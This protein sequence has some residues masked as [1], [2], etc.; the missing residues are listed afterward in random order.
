FYDSLE[1]LSVSE[2]TLSA[3][4]LSVSSSEEANQLC[5]ALYEAAKDAAPVIGTVEVS[6]DV[7]MMSRRS[8]AAHDRE[9][10][11]PHP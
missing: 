1:K 11:L 5:Q 8:D 10:G 2:T 3:I 6:S 4:S 7:S 9:C